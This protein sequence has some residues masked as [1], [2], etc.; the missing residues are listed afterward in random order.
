MAA[1]TGIP[2]FINAR[3]DVYLKGKDFVSEEEK[4]SETIKRGKA[5]KDAGAD[6][7]VPK[8]FDVDDLLFRIKN[9]LQSN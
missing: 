6:C 8:P 7:F 2:L 5:Y 9:H 1:E 3:T 4:L